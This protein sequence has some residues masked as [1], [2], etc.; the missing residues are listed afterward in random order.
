[1]IEQ[2]KRIRYDYD[3]IRKLSEAYYHTKVDDSAT[4]ALL[5]NAMKGKTVLVLAPGGSLNE[6]GTKIDEYIKANNPVTISVNFIA[7]NE[8]YA[9]FSNV[10]RYRKAQ[11]QRQG[12]RCIVVSNIESDD[13]AD[14]I[15]NYESLVDREFEIFYNSMYMLL[16]LLRRI[17]VASFAIAGLDG[18]SEK[19]SNSFYS[20]KMEDGTTWEKRQK[21]NENLKLM[22]EKYVK[23]MDSSS[24]V[25]FLTPSLFE[26]IFKGR[27]V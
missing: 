21:T 16:T 14:Y 22:L 4:L 10:R 23:G 12:K 15:V 18:F 1:M 19:D 7:G 13:P 6:F 8:N 17:G 2:E 5:Q 9:F 24:R 25:E 3:N 27:L 11:Q 26:K 20:E